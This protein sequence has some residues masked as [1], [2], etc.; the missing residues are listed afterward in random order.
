MHGRI[1]QHRS[2]VL[3]AVL[4]RKIRSLA[5]ASAYT[6]AAHGGGERLGPGEVTVD[7]HR[8]R[9]LDG[10][11]KAGAVGR[12]AEH[13]HPP[14][15]T[16][17]SIR[18]RVQRLE[19]TPEFKLAI[20]PDELVGPNLAETKPLAL[21]GHRTIRDDGGQLPALAR[22]VRLRFKETP[23]LVA[24]HLGQAREEVLD[25]AELGDELL[26]RLLADAL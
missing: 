18:L 12:I 26:R 11:D 1:F 25:G 20:E 9:S 19:Q 8:R 7:R 22:C 21:E 5:L 3:Q 2:N 13:S 6:D 17:L 4:P 16:R 14:F 15:A 24:L 23:E 10:C